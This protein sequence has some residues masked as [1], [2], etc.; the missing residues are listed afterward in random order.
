M[1][2][3]A[4]LVADRLAAGVGLHDAPASTEETFWAV[5]RLLEALARRGPVVLSFDDL[6]WAE[7]TFLD[8]IEYLARW[9]RDL[10]SDRVREV[11]EIVGYH[12][13]AASSRSRRRLSPPSSTC[14]ARAPRRHIANVLKMMAHA[15]LVGRSS[16][17]PA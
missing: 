6:H 11:E 13:E 4:R 7:P 9:I 16:A 10:P 1:S 14:S 12:L 5:R 2:P 15:A 8:L 17:W 3:T